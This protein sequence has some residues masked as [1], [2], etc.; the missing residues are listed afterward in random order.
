MITKNTPIEEVAAIVSQTLKDNGITAVLSGGAAVS[1]YT[2]NKYQTGDLDFVTSCHND[3]IAAALRPLGYEQAADRY[4]RHPENDYFLEFPPGPVMVGDM[5]LQEYNSITL[6]GNVL[7]VLTPT[8]CVMN[9]LADF[10]YYNDRECFKLAILLTKEQKIDLN[11]VK[12][13]SVKE[14]QGLKFKEFTQALKKEGIK[15]DMGFDR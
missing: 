2:H 7:T 9:K 13:W 5:H 14:G 11:A 1:I 3:R 6:K 12:K 15:Y 4:L 8:Q 10:Y